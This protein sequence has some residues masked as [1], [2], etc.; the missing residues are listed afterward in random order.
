LSLGRFSNYRVC[1]LHGVYNIKRY[2]NTVAKQV[3]ADI[4]DSVRQTVTINYMTTNRA[5]FL[6]LSGTFSRPPR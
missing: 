2:S 6:V 4:V 3:R 1:R 5:W